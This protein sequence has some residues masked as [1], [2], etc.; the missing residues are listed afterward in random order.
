V[1]GYWGQPITPVQD[2]NSVFSPILLPEHL[3]EQG[4]FPPGHYLTA[5]KI[6]PEEENK[7]MGFLK[8]KSNHN[9][10]KCF[11]KHPTYM[12]M[13]TKFLLFKCLYY[14]FLFSFPSL[15]LSNTDF[16]FF[17]LQESTK[18]CAWH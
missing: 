9:Q 11:G 18:Q 16:K 15:L 7:N 3:L 5:V 12:Y 4:G 10:S 17:F 6:K 13:F 8:S 1:S 14:L 2:M